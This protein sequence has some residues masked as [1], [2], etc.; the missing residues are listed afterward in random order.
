MKTGKMFIMTCILSVVL[1]CTL[2]AIFDLQDNTI[3]TAGCFAASAQD[4]NDTYN[5]TYGNWTPENWTMPWEGWKDIC[6]GAYCILYIVIL[7]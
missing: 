2:G 3:N 7:I 6:C 5:Y 1:L 4:G